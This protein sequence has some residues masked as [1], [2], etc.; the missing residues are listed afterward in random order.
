[1]NR[2]GWTWLLLAGIPLVLGVALRLLL[3]S[4][5]VQNPVL[6]LTADLG[7]LAFLC[8]AA[9]AA[10]VAGAIAWFL[11]LDRSQRRSLAEVQAEASADRRRFLQ[12]LD[13]E[14]KNPLTAIQAGLANLNETAYPQALESVKAQSQR[15]NRLVAD[16]RKLA[17][18]ETR[19]IEHAQV[20]LG[21]ILVTVI[22]MAEEDPRA[23]GREIRLA[24]P[25]A[26]WPL[27]HI[28]GDYDLLLLAMHNLVDNALKFS[29]PGD[30]IETRAFEDGSALVVE[31]ADTG[32]GIPP[33]ELPHVW[34][35]L[36]RGEGARGVQGSGL[37]MALV[38]AIVER[39]G[40]S[41][42]VRSR[43][44]QGTVVTVH[45]PLGPGTNAD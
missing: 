43:V 5:V 12:R 8:G 35:E 2:R 24:L 33:A 23:Q 16:L 14:M 41:T 38:R 4:G 3:A 26:P 7:T 18:L 27:P 42:A 21:E 31:V 1:M 32:P 44:G 36:Y 6:N 17:D 28:N 15:L 19:P 30:R 22:G 39:H 20:D 45:L 9:L 34:E 13:H 37:G 40:G 10:G 25:Q 11:W 29:E